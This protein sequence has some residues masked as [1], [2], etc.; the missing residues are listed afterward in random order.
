MRRMSFPVQAVVLV[1]DGAEEVAGS[2]GERQ[3]CDDLI[4]RL[5]VVGEGIGV[6]DKRGTSSAS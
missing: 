3:G 4:F 6:A 5:Q 1:A 2:S